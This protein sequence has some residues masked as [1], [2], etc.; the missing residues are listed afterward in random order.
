M[1]LHAYMLRST[2]LGFYAMFPFFRSSFLLYVDLGYVLTCLISCLW[3]CF[4]RIYV[5]VC[6]LP[7]FM[8]RS[9]LVHAYTLG[10][11]FFHAYVLSFHMLMHVLHMPMP[12]SMFMF[13]DLR[14]HILACLDLGFHMLVC[15]DLC[16]LA[17]MLYLSC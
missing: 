8:L 14:F 10:F 6:F 11:M 1:F 15:L 13:L 9:A 7:Y 2:C 3:L 16:L 4:S 5:F 17:F 12:R